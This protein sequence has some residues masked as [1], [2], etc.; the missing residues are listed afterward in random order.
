GAP[1]GNG[2]RVAR[3]VEKPDQAT[4]QSYLDS[5]KYLW[6]AGMFCFQAATVLQELERHAPEVL[7]AARAALA[8]GSSLENGQCR[9]R[10][11]AA[12]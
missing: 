2:F 12:G 3:F 7:I 10:E 9:Q 1:L 8:D 11:L 5:G 6:N 4:A